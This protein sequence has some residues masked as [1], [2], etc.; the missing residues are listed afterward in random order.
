MTRFIQKKIIL[1]IMKRAH[2]K[3]YRITKLSTKCK[4]K[5]EDPKITISKFIV[6]FELQFSRVKH[7]IQKN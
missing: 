4:Y 3:K 7:D 1:V 5:L 6:Y 2:I